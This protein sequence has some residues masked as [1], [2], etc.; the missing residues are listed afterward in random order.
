MLIGLSFKVAAVPFHMWTPDVYQGAPSSVTAFMA[1]GAKGAGFAALLRVL[2]S[3]FPAIQGDLVPIIGAL[4]VLTMI[5][6][7]LIAIVQSNIKRMLAYSSIAHAGNILM[8]LVAFG[9]KEI[10]AQA[11][12]SSLFYLVAYALANFGAWGVVIAVEKN[13]QPRG[14][15]IADYSGLGRRHPWLAAAMTISLLSFIGVPP[16][17]GFVG[18][19]FL[20][21]TV[22]QAGQIGLALIGVLASLISA[23]YY[24]RV[25]VTMYM[26]EGEPEARREIWLN[27]AIAGSAVGTILLTIFS[28]V[29]FDWAARALLVLF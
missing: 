10:A 17:L 9:Q 19:F 15:G 26:Q 5:F 28:P 22:L 25:I 4:S 29:L 1:A 23:Y 27:L 24:L 12:A 14:P 6:G 2:I 3:A 21:R 16:T 8:A 20:F 7:N 13:E 18:K 11:V